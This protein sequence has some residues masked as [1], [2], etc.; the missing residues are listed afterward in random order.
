MG[1]MRFMLPVVTISIFIT[2]INAQDFIEIDAVSS[3]S[4]RFEILGG[5]AYKDYAEVTWSDDYSNGS[6][7]TLKWGKKYLDNSINLKP[8]FSREVITTTITGLTPGTTYKAQFYRLFHSVD[9]VTNFTFTTASNDATDTIDAVNLAGE[10][11]EWT[12]SVDTYGSTGSVTQ[13]SNKVTAT[14]NFVATNE[15]DNICPYQVARKAPSF[16]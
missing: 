4:R 7:H 11:Y 3:A 10:D 2:S 6:E 9:Y 1:L 8:F 14:F 5:K 16:R 12:S 15:T 13:S